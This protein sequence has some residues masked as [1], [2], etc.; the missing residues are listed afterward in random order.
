MSGSAPGGSGSGRNSIDRVMQLAWHPWEYGLLA[1]LV[2]GGSGRRSP[3]RVLQLPWLPS[4]PRT[5]S[6]TRAAHA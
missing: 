2:Y 4:V 3:D 6:L 1:R 5:V